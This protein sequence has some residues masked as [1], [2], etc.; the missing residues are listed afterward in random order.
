MKYVG[1]QKALALAMMA[2]FAS[3]SAYAAVDI[4]GKTGTVSYAKELKFDDTSP[5]EFKTAAGDAANTGPL[6]LSSAYGSGLSADK[7]YFVRYQLSGGEWGDGT[8]P[9]ST[10]IAG[11]QPSTA[12]ASADKAAVY[13]APTDNGAFILPLNIGSTAGASTDTLKIDFAASQTVFRSTTAKPIS[14]GSVTITATIFEDQVDANNNNASR[15]LSSYTADYIKTDATVFAYDETDYSS[16]A[17]TIDVLQESK[18][19]TDGTTATLKTVKLCEIQIQEST[20]LL[21]NGTAANANPGVIDAVATTSVLKVKGNL[22][23]IAKDN[24]YTD[25]V[26]KGRIF[27]STGTGGAPGTATA[28]TECGGNAKEV[29]TNDGTYTRADSVSATEASFTIGDK[30]AKDLADGDTSAANT[31][32]VSVCMTVNG[33]DPIP[34]GSFEVSYEPVAAT[35]YAVEPKT[36]AKCSPLNK[37]GSTFTVPLVLN[38]GSDFI[39]FIRLTNPSTTEGVVN[40]MAYNDD[41][42]AGSSVM[43]VTLKA[44]QS[45]GMISM[46]DI[47]TATG[48][49]V[50]TTPANGTA[51]TPP[52]KLR[53]HIE[54][55]FGAGHNGSDQTG[56]IVRSYAMTKDR[57]GFSEFQ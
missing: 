8:T 40:I 16:S 41:G 47:A 21:A 44:G 48:A 7:Q 2:M 22:S 23:A 29:G 42:V 57:N 27:L 14:G 11:A 39:Q 26:V 6:D 34:S 38:P 1:K 56:V 54:A 50:L 12:N 46:S 3:G 55:E 51:G 35:G 15:S 52:N 37:N 28:L 32:K 31:G 25:N 49:T 17:N 24:A 9:L 33:V 19:F 20:A 43:K 10:L 53:L 13:Y 45:S 5:A 36:F 4:S 30:T 18:F